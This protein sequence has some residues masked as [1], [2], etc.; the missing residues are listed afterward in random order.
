V[1]AIVGALRAILSL[2]SAAFTS[3]LKQA[4]KG[5]TN[6]SASARKLGGQMQ[7]VGAVASI[8]GAAI[9]AGLKGAID[10]ADAL[11]ELSQKIGVPVEQLSALQYAF[12]KSGVSSETMAAG[13]GKLSKAMA[14]AADGNKASAKMFADLGIKVTDATGA[15]RPA[16]DVMA[17]VAGIFADM[18]DG[19]EKTALAMQLFGKS[20]AEMIPALNEGK[21]GLAG[22][23]DEAR[24]LGI[25]IDSETAASAGKFNDNLFTLGAAASGLA[26][27]IAADLLPTLQKISDFLVDMAKA[28]ADLSPGMQEFIANVA[29]AIVVGG[30]LLVGLGLMVSAVGHV[31][32]AFSALAALIMANPLA[33]AVALIAGG[34][35]LIWYNWDWLK[36]QFSEIWQSIKDK[37]VAAWDYIKTTIADAI[38]FVQAKWEIFVAKIEAAIQTAKDAAKAIGDALSIGR[39]EMNSGEGYQRHGRGHGWQPGR[40]RPDELRA[41]QGHRQGD[42]RRHG[43]WPAGSDAAARFH[44]ARGLLCAG[45][46]GPRCAGHRVA[47]QGVQGNRRIPD[48]GLGA[49][50]QRGQAAGR[51][52]HGPMWRRPRP[53]RRPRQPTR[54]ATPGAGC[55]ASGSPG[56][57]R[58]GDA[59]AGLADRLA[60]MLA[61]S[62]FDGLFGSGGLF[63]GIFDSL[64]GAFGFAKGGV[65]AGGRVT[66][67]A[68]G[69]V[70]TGPTPFPM[71]G[72]LGLMGEAGPEAIMPLTRGPGGKLGVQAIGGG[73]SVVRLVVEE[74]PMFA[75]RVRT[76]AQGVAVD[77]VR[78]YDAE[79][80]PASRARP[81]REVG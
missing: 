46:D 51:N 3:G 66:A 33:A 28:Y 26:V 72:G 6:F 34:A 10:S 44:H 63:G 30:P 20:G 65:F 64:A 61:E 7:K 54:C 68:T 69:G 80:A 40:G 57:R 49:W 50:H 53:K 76:E 19:A 13:V 67:F 71:R 38:A 79:V 5:L 60:D 23:M 11:D 42:R 21:A 16:A 24:K 2:E 22:L 47:F 77:V 31:G 48:P 75:A 62:A 56:R 52:G 58:R 55:S 59:L 14:A 29:G 73:G 37:A 39:E 18:P 1:S 27:Q 17:D 35:Y 25:V 15:L 4:Q 70:V 36:Q 78:Q 74:N 8:A 81:P 41:R 43:G 32:A 9:V 45:Q 12:E